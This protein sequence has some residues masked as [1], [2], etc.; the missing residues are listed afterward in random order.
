MDKVAKRIAKRK[1]RECKDEMAKYKAIYKGIEESRR[2]AGNITTT[3]ENYRGMLSSISDSTKAFIYGM[4]DYSDGAMSVING[5]VDKISGLINHY[6]AMLN[7]QNRI[8]LK[9]KELYDEQKALGFRIQDNFNDTLD[10]DEF[11]DKI[12]DMGVNLDI[13]V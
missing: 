3:I 5:N 12:Y 13:F 9:A 4:Y 10:W 7:E 8:S 2:Y 11:M 6:E 1:I